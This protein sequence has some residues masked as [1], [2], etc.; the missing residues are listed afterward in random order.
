MKK[1]EYLSPEL[2]VIEIKMQTSTT[3]GAS[4]SGNLGNFSDGGVIE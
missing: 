1:K 2:S 4:G 3:V